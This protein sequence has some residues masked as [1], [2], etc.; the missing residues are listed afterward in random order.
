MVWRQD[1]HGNPILKLKG[2]VFIL[3]SFILLISVVVP[4]GSGSG[5]VLDL[6]EQIVE[7]QGCGAAPPSLKGAGGFCF[8]PGSNRPGPGAGFS[9]WSEPSRTTA[10]PGQ[11]LGLGLGLD[12]ATMGL[13]HVLVHLLVPDA[14]AH[15]S[16]FDQF[17]LIPFALRTRQLRVMEGTVVGRIRTG[18]ILMCWSPTPPLPPPPTRE[19]IKS[20]SSMPSDDLSKHRSQKESRT[21]PE[22]LDARPRCVM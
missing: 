21:P 5:A 9:S 14:R 16:R 10:G 13:V 6:L 20:C 17:A 8:S 4:A 7:L 22:M 2:L 11:P 3:S 15:K 1:R 18:G 19:Y 12:R